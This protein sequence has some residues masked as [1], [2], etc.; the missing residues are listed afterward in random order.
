MRL[1]VGVGGRLGGGFWMRISG[2]LGMRTSAGFHANTHF[3]L[4]ANMGSRIIFAVDLNHAIRAA[5]KI[6]IG[7][8][9]V[10][11]DSS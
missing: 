10:N 2:G 11:D 9:D 6:Q 1:T 3:R 5:E 4:Q 7:L 8:R